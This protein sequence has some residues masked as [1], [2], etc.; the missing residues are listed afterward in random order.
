MTDHPC[1]L[2]R[3]RPGEA[4]VTLT[5]DVPH[6]KQH[7]Y[8]CRACVRLLH[9]LLSTRSNELPH[10]DPVRLAAYANTPPDD[11]DD[12]ELPYTLN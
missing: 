5:S 2:C 9:D 12:R 3:L 6:Q 1:Y 4:H 10:A 7:S 11:D 8:L